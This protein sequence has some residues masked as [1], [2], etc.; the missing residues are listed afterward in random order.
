MMNR[1]RLEKIEGIYH[2][3]IDQPPDKRDSFLDDSCGDDDELRREV[4]SLL[5]YDNTSSDLIDSS[6]AWLAVELFGGDV[7]AV[8]VDGKI[9]HYKVERL[10]GEGGMGQVY[11]AEDMRLH[12]RVA[13]KIL[14]QSIVG[15]AERL[16]RFEREA[17]V[18]SA[19]NHPNII[20][21]HEFGEGN[22]VHFIASEFVD[23]R[24]LRQKLADGV[25]DLGEALDIAIQVSSALIAAHDAGITHRDIK[26][27]NIMLRQDG[28][29]KVLDF[30]L[31]KLAEPQSSSSSGSEDPTI[32]LHRTKPG[33]VMG[34]AAYMS[35]EQA[36]GRHVD[37]RTDIWSLGAVIYEMLTGR[38]PFSGETTADVIVSVISTEPPMVSSYV[39][40]LPP[41]LDWMIAKMLSK[42][43]DTRFQTV[44]ELRGDLDRIRKKIE[45]DKT[46][47]RSGSVSVEGREEVGKDQSTAVH[48]MPTTD[49][50]EKPTDDGSTGHESF[51]SSPSFESVVREV[52]THKVGSTVV[53]FILLALVSFGVYLVFLAP[54]ASGQI[55]SI[56]VL[57]FENLTGDAGLDYAS[58]GISEGLID[59]LSQ[60]PQLKVISRTSSSKFRGPD[61]DLK[62]VA[63]QLG[64]RSIATGRVTRVGDDIAIRVDIVDAIDDKQ[65][66][67]GQYVR[68]AT[69]VANIQNEIAQLA[70]DKLKLP[71]T[72]AQSKRLKNKDTENAEAFR[73]YLSGLVAL[74]SPEDVRGKA[75]DYFEQAVKLDPDF[76]AAH[77]EIGWIYW[78]QANASG[79]PHEIM[80]KVKA[81]ADRS[82]ALDPDLPKAHVLTATVKEYEF[83][84]IGA[85]SSY[86]R[87]IELSPSLDFARNNYAF[88]LSI[89][90]RHDDALRQL[91]EQQMRDPINK[92]L[93]L[94][95]KGIVLVQARRFDDALRAYQEAQAVEPANEVPAFALG[96]A[97][98]GKG[99]HNEAVSNYRAAI[100]TLGGDEKYTQPLVYLAATYAVMP[101]K[102]DEA[103]SILARIETMSDY[104]SPALLSAVYS[105]LDDNDKAMELLEQAY[106][107]RDLLLRFI[108]TGY[109]YDGLRDDPRFI[110]LLRRMGMSR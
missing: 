109:E 66:A 59:R 14:S 40:G 11:L 22:G 106:I 107:R 62:K 54:R 34:T 104:K 1:T 91:E 56:A 30:G 38:R 86:R 53:A 31:A 26:P 94:L 27:E 105:A 7:N 87:A 9:N 110:D 100:A 92:R 101:D 47:S 6:P 39:K 44:K 32:V 67:G 33:A 90:G 78:S 97:Y 15:D 41:E 49:D 60:L 76:A 88:Y 75:L 70:A 99:L 82:L 65:I 85:D 61:L 8:F 55:D 81:A 63:S 108:G 3:V 46:F 74:N 35:P 52:Q 19:L 98:A 23:G 73:Y 84:W 79:D 51:W 68:K 20:T 77:A 48:A 13:L 21:I 89:I 57:P 24:T 43:L 45:F 5:R 71:L 103:R 4:E 28:Y 37:G 64:V 2:A 17:H 25:M 58:E 69:E 29:I 36:R 42:D 93:G 102:R 96:Y 50:G 16:L 12:R 18:V 80:P 10:L 72:D 83:D 95:Q